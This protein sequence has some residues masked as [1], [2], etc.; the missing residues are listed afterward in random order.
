MLNFGE[1]HFTHQFLY[2][3]FLK[4][5]QEKSKLKT[6]KQENKPLMNN[7]RLLDEDYNLSES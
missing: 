6:K 5:E 2:S 4:S 1:I 3:N 7:R